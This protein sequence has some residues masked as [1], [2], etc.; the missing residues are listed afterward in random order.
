MPD[1]ASHSTASDRP[2]EPATKQSDSKARQVH[3][4]SIDPFSLVVT[5]FL[6]PVGLVFVAWSLVARL[7]ALRGAKDAHARGYLRWTLLAHALY[8]YA[9]L[10]LGALTADALLGA[11]WQVG[12]WWPLLGAWDQSTHDRTV[13]LL[14]E[15]VG[16]LALALIALARA[17]MFGFIDEEGVWRPRRR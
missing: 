3:P 9:A 1:P 5:P 13:F 6:I 17:R 12:E 16:V 11:P 10:V 14:A 4:M 8:G 2:L 15:V 7:R